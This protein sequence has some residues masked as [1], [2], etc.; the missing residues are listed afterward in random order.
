MRRMGARF[1]FGP[2]LL[3]PDAGTLLR[4]DVP[5]AVGYRGL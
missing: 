1:A 4:D 5:V 2:F 3:D